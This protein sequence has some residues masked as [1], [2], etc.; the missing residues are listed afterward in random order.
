MCVC[1]CARVRV[2][3]VYAGGLCTRGQR[4]R[5]GAFKLFSEFACKQPTRLPSNRL[6]LKD[7]LPKSACPAAQDCNYSKNDD[8]LAGFLLRMLRTAR[9]DP[10]IPAMLTKKTAVLYSLLSQHCFLFISIP[11]I[12]RLECRTAKAA[13]A[14]APSFLAFYAALRCIFG[15][16]P[17]RL[18]LSFCTV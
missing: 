16:S 14:A 18:A 2:L 8:S 12:G 17:L 6:I 3:K 7:P 5:L 13:V 10:A 9:R 15:V 11:S 4:G 1:V